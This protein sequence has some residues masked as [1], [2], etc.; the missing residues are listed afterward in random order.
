MAGLVNPPVFVP[1]ISTYHAYFSSPDTNLFSREYQAVLEPYLIDPMN[2]GAAQTPA[3]VSLQIYAS[4]HQG[5]PTAI[6][7]WHATPEIAKDC[8]PGCV[9]LLHSVSHYV[10]RMGCLS[11]QWDDRMFANRGDVSYGTPPLVVWDPTYLHLAP[12]VYVP[13]AAAIDTSLDGD[14]NVTLLGPYSAGDAG[15][16]IIRC[17]K[18]FYVPAPYVGL[19]LSDDLIPV[20]VWNRLRGAIVYAAAEAACRP[21][22]NWLHAAIVR[23]GPNTYSALVVP[24][25]L[26]P[27]PDALL[28]QHRHR[29]LLIHLPALKPALTA[30]QGPVLPKRLERWQWS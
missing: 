19:L 28:L 22:I 1:T 29:L 2:V 6:L 13:S 3:S 7:L 16:E 24:N 9:S 4:S 26:A 23:S 15:A 27:L 14:P 25:P 5:D 12:G 8:N 17:R 10:S 30:R 11:S 18:T 20:E 21:V